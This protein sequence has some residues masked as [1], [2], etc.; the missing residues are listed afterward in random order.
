[1]S[2][3]SV[4]ITQS[5]GVVVMQTAG[6]TDTPL[7]RST[8]FSLELLLL[9][10]LLLLSLLLLLLLLLLSA[11]SGIEGFVCAQT[12]WCISKKY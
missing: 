4:W 6:W 9:L 10:L 7:T 8:I 3:R 11:A 5:S 1:M 12:F 2:G